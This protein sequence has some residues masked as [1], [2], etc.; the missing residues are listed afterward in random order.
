[1]FTQ[2]KKLLGVGNYNNSFSGKNLWLPTKLS[3]LNNAE[4]LSYMNNLNNSLYPSI[5]NNGLHNSMA[6]N[7]TIKS[8]SILNLNLFEHSRMWITKKF[9]FNNQ[10]FNNIV[11]HSK[12]YNMNS[13]LP[14]NTTLSPKKNILPTNITSTLPNS[15]ADLSSSVWISV[16]IR[17]RT[18]L[19]SYLKS[20]T[21]ALNTQNLDLLSST[22]LSFISSITSNTK[23][24]R[25][26]NYYDIT[27]TT[28]ILNVEN[29]LPRFSNNPKS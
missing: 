5:L 11:S 13:G 29:T 10:M 26:T 7:S 27:P 8:P 25:G 15:A 24:T 4:T 23:S 21:L 6:S 2:S 18:N 16:G 1:M 14:H 17:P 12:S 20:D 19:N 28:N 9:F 3:N 22:D